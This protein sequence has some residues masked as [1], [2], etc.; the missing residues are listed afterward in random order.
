KRKSTRPFVNEDKQRTIIAPLFS[1]IYSPF[2]PPL[3]E[4]AGYKLVNLPKPDKQSVEYGLKYSNN[5]ICYP[6]TI[7]IGDIMKALESG[8][9]NRN[10]IAVG[11]TQTGGQCRASSYLSLIRKAMVAA[12]YEDI[13]VVSVSSGSGIINS[14]PGFKIDWQKILKVA[15]V[16]ALY[17]DSLAKMYYSTVVRE[18]E[19]GISKQLL[20]KYIELSHSYITDKNLSGLYRLLSLAIEEFNLVGVYEREYPRIGIV[21][22][23]YVKYNSYGSLNVIDWLISQGVEVVVPPLLDFF[24]Q[25][26]VNID[27]DKKLNLRRKAVISDMYINFIEKKADSHLRKTEKINS[28]FRYYTHFHKIRD[29]SDKAKDILSLANQ[30]GEG[31][32]IPAEIAAFAGD[33]VLNVV[34]LQPFGCIANQVISKGVETKIRDLYPNMNLLFL[35]FDDGTTEVNVLNRLHFLI[36]NMKK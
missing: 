35:D 16:A 24:T 8:K 36:R 4:L 14:Q 13:P 15:F 33:G 28:K 34:S 3:F 12:G 23:I 17:A 18:K 2:I 19:K 7:V 21:G 27:A 26:F 30:Y 32:L 11:I 10:E 22:E 5:E 25:S 20:E 31:W 6:A 9:Y 29:I 1:D